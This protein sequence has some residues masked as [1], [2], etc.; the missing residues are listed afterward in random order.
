MGVSLYPYQTA[1]LEGSPQSFIMAADTGLGKS[2]LSL[3][4]Y[5]N[6]NPNHPLLIVAPASKVRTGEWDDEVH[7]ALG[8]TFTN[9]TVLSYEMFTKKHRELIDPT[10]TVIFDEVHY[11]ANPTSK[12]AKAA[13]LTARTAEQWIGL[14]ATPTPNGWRSA[15]TYAIVTGL[16]RNKTAFEQRFIITDRSRTTFPLFLGY[17][18]ESVLEEWWSHVAK[19]LKR[20]G[21]LV[22]P[23]QTIGKRIRLT[24]KASREYNRIKN[25]RVYE[26]ELLDSAP[27]LF[28][29]MRQY[30][31]LY[32]LDTI[33]SILDGTDEHVV[34][35][36][37]YNVER[38]ALLELLARR[39]PDRT[40]YEQNGHNSTLPKRAEWDSLP[41]A[42]V[43]IGQ[44][45]SASTGIEL[46]YT[47]VTIYM[48]PT[49][50]Y[51]TFM[52]S[53]G[54]NLR[55]GQDKQVLF[56]MLNVED[57]I[58]GDVYKA[59]KNKRDFDEKLLTITPESV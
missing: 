20:T 53:K 22:L 43:T 9:Y 57:T 36:Y 58:D 46:T 33:E 1:Y 50:S 6:H 54:R 56:Y 3:A 12:R 11:I 18:E 2:R 15:G 27:K 14:S 16:A 19:P 32:R 21:N 55:N 37:N 42:T 26:G 13:I 23:S 44:Y 8:D 31:T 52:Q 17:R 4:H 48:S 39:F 34:I 28:A 47:S 7:A 51:S 30:L 10:I 35:F 45:Q 49:Y 29:T 38:T 40:V 25:T 59:L 24:P 41:P 5:H